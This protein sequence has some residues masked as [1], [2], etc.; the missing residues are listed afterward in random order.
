[1]HE[2]LLSEE[3]SSGLSLETSESIEQENEMSA[4][5]SSLDFNFP[6]YSVTSCYADKRLEDVTRPEKL[7]CG[8]KPDSWLYLQ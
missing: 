6:E 5:N 4:S 2:K 3:F 1:M 8:Y 7:G